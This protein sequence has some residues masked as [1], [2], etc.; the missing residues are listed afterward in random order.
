VAAPHHGGPLLHA[1]RE[2]LGRGAAR[3]S[4]RAG[5][6]LGRPTRRPRREPRNGRRQV[7]DRVR[8]TRV[9]L[10]MGHLAPIVTR[11]SK[12]KEKR[13]GVGSSVTF[14]VS[15]RHGESGENLCGFSLS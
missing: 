13:A 11:F 15:I 5:A 14:S 4:L 9:F 3:P 10:T 12:E 2:T 6:R 8:R 1:L 7:L